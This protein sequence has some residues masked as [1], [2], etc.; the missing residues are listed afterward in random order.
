[1][2]AVTGPQG[3]LFD[4]PKTAPV[5]PHLDYDG[6][7]SVALLYTA[8]ERGNHSGVRFGMSIKDA[9]AWCSSNVSRGQIGGT[10]WA[11]FWTS[12]ANYVQVYYRD[13]W[14]V[15]DFSKDFDSGEWDER[16][17]EL[18]LRKYG[19]DELRSLLAPM[20]VNVIPPVS[21]MRRES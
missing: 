11:Y 5:R 21:R 14:P 7:R 19:F 9:M 15:F 13:G 6:L 16:I 20:G 2:G 12:A 18:G 3:S 10:K 1:M 4:V 8:T 17:A